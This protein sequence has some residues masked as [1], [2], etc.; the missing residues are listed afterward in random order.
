MSESDWTETGLGQEPGADVGDDGDVPD[1][2]LLGTEDDLL[3]GGGL[4]DES[5]EI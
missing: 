3:E 5:D 2:P 1:N 4:D